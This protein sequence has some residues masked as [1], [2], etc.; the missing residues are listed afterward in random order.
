[1]F[2]A[3]E[4]LDLEIF[5]HKEEGNYGIFIVLILRIHTSTSTTT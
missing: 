2:V 3:E 1:M 4:M 5:R